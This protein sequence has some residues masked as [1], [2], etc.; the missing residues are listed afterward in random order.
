MDVEYIVD[1]SF[2]WDSSLFRWLGLQPFIISG[3][4]HAERLANCR[5]EAYS[6]ALDQIDNFVPLSA[7]TASS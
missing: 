2:H 4:D 6:M 5:H 1:T 3:A 7:S